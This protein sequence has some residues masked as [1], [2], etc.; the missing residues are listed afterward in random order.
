[1]Q[2]S[3]ARRRTHT[4]L[5]RRLLTIFFA[6]AFISLICT[7]VVYCTERHLAREVESLRERLWG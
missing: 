5:R 1:L 2:W 4:H 3:R 7:L 6:T